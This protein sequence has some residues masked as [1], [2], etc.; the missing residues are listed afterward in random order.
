M[1][2]HKNAKHHRECFKAWKELERNLRN[3]TG[4]ID[5]E[6]YV[7]IEKKAKMACNS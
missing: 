4:I 5:A 2:V 7:Q 6:F 3:K 1:I